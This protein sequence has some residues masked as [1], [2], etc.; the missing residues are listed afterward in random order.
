M[1]SSFFG[2]VQNLFLEFDPVQDNLVGPVRN[3]WEFRELTEMFSFMSFGTL[4]RSNWEMRK[5]KKKKAVI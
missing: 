4:V 5:C 2:I 3:D 1:E